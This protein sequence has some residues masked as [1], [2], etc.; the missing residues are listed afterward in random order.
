MEIIIIHYNNYPNGNYPN[1][2]PTNYPNGGGNYGYGN[3][4]DD[5]GMKTLVQTMKNATFD[6]KKMIAVAKNCFKK[7]SIKNKSGVHELLQKLNFL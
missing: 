1:N 7:Q 6:E 2:Y 3:V 4:M 5:A